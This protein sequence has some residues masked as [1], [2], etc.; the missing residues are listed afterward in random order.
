MNTSM[1]K[2]SKQFMA[3]LA[4]AVLC[5][6]FAQAQDA[7]P[8]AQPQGDPAAQQGQRTDGQIEIDRKSVV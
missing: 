1:K 6:V 8:A 4:L 3:S 2:V 5:T 7:G